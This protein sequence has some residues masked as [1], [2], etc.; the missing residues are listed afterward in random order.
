MIMKTIMNSLNSDLKVNSLIQCSAFCFRSVL[1]PV[2]IMGTMLCAGLSA[3][4]VTPDMGTWISNGTVYDIK[5]DNEFTYIGGSF[6]HIGPN[7]GGA[8]MFSTNIDQPDLSFPNV[9]GTVHVII[10]DGSG[11]WYIGGEF[12]QVDS[13]VR[14]RL[15]RI[16]SDG[17]VHPWTGPSS[18]GFVYAM[19]LHENNLIFG[20]TFQVVGDQIRNNIASASTITGELNEDFNPNANGTVRTL[21]VHNGD[22]FVGG[23]FFNIGGQLRRGIAKL[24]PVTGVA[25]ADWNANLN[26]QSGINTMAIDGNHLYIGGNYFIGITRT[27]LSRLDIADGTIDAA[28]TTDADNTIH[29]IVISGEHLYI[30]G[31]FSIVGNQLRTR[32]AKIN[33]LNG[34][35]DMQWNPSATADV[36]DLAVGPD[37]IYAVGMFNFVSDVEVLRI[38]KLDFVFGQP[39]L[40]WNPKTNGTTGL[41]RA[42]T[43]A[44]QGNQ[45]YVGGTFSIIGGY[46]RNNLARISNETGLVDADWAPSLNNIVFS[47]ALSNNTVYVGGAFTTVDGAPINRLARLS[48]HDGELD[49]DWNPNVTGGQVNSVALDGNFI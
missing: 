30:G 36:L 6:S 1:I 41:T 5:A 45:I 10:P 38:T 33:K 37:G 24:N 44:I 34:L 39:N 32:L 2:I 26:T 42:S 8:A 27:R 12:T 19:A 17:S 43:V 11:G 16:N 49:S 35:V 13:A 4:S 40:D 46:S 23:V 28:W 3:Q 22:L 9:N 25:D 48:K 15:A 7:T 18:V 47:I 21:K 29:A 20:G 14:S 31:I